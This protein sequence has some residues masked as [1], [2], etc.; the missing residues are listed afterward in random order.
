MTPQQTAGTWCCQPDQTGHVDG[1]VIDLWRLSTE[2]HSLEF[3]FQNK[4]IKRNED[5]NY[6]IPR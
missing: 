3:Q 1:H 4:G 2:T 6:I 5:E